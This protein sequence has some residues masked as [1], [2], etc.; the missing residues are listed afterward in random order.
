LG[1][2][3]SV[4][5]AS[6]EDR[7]IRVYVPPAWYAILQCRPGEIG[8]DQILKLPARKSLGKNRTPFVFFP[9]SHELVLGNANSRV[10]GLHSAVYPHPFVLDDH[11][12]VPKD[13]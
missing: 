1:L 2:D 5:V 9:G 6:A 8:A 11:T 12:R 4:P 7:Y 3:L 10:H 13:T